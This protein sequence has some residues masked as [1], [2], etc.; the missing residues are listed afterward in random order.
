MLT[1]VKKHDKVVTSGGIHGVV[2]G[3]GDHD[4]TLKI[5]ES[6]NVRVKFTRSAIATILT[7]D[8]GEKDAS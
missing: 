8:T 1:A 2:V 4:I 3:V 5:D 6:S 7:E